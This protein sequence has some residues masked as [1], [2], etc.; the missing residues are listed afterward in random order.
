MFRFHLD[1]I[2]P[3]VARAYGSVVSGAGRVG[4][5][6]QVI[7]ASFSFDQAS[8]DLHNRALNK[9]IDLSARRNEIAHGK[10]SAPTV[11]DEYFGH[12]LMPPSYN[13]GKNYTF[14]QFVARADQREPNA[15]LNFHL[16]SCKYV[17]T[18]VEI[19]SYAAMFKIALKDLSA[20]WLHM[21]FRR[22]ELRQ[23]AGV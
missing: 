13:T 6:K 5:L 2:H 8:I 20:M 3:G 10:V 23:Q 14:A 16:S 21:T 22:G 12:C 4:M 15:W 7:E 11:N 9:I 17:Y 1:T 18:P 19:D